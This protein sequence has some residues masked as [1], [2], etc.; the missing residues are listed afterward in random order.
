MVI[1]GS[2]AITQMG[3]Y[4]F[5]LGSDDGSIL[6]IGDRYRASGLRLNRAG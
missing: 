5:Y 6:T 3:T 1:T 4:A 2:I